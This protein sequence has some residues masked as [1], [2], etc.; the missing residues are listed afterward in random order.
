MCGRERLAV[1]ADVR[2]VDRHVAPAEHALALD[3]DVELEQ[4]LELAPQRLVARQEA[5][6]DAVGPAGGSSNGQTARRNASGIWMRIPAPSP[7]Q[8]VG[9]LRPAVLEVV[10]R[11]ERADDD[12]VGG[13]VV[14]PRDHRDAAGVVLVARVVQAVS[15]WRL[16]HRHHEVPAFGGAVA[17][18]APGG[19]AGNLTGARALA[20]GPARSALPAWRRRGLLARRP[21]FLA[22]GFLA[23]RLL[24]CALA[25]LRAR[26]GLGRPSRAASRL[27]FSALMRSGTGL[28]GLAPARPRS[29]SARPAPC[30][31]RGRGRARGTRPCSAPGS[32]SAASE[33]IS[34]SAMSSSRLD[35]SASASGRRAP[36]R[37]RVDDLVGEQQRRQLERDLGRAQRDEVLLGAQHDAGDADA[38][39]RAHRLEQ[40]PVGLGAARGR[41]DVVRRVVEDRVD[42]RAVDE[43]LDL[44]RAA[45]LGIERLELLLA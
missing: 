3:A 22:A 13:L 37:R 17:A 43:V 20:A 28:C 33:P 18:G 26:R 41:R 34:C 29:R 31:R 9:A 30:A 23:A 40:Q 24:R 6:A 35:G 45:A 25:R 10:E 32:K 38:A 36:R 42:L 16:D 27:A 4:L 15:L 11:L 7:V 14:E 1:V 12:V 2:L 21:G 8:H 39:A 19:G 5:D 44:D